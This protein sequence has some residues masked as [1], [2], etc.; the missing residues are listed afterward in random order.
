METCD[1]GHAEIVYTTGD[2]PLCKLM[3]T[4]E[5]ELDNFK[6]K[7]E[8]EIDTLKE[9]AEEEADN[10]KEKISDLEDIIHDLKAELAGK[11]GQVVSAPTPEKSSILRVFRKL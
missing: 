5:D 8:E 4:A 3:E 7:S 9:K 6:E 1:C 10:L 11:G 2:C